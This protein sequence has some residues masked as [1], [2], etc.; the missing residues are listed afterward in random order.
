MGAWE[1]LLADTGSLVAAVHGIP[2]RPGSIGQ[3]PDDL[4]SQIRQGLAARG[5]D[6]PWKHQVD[7]FAA[8]TS[9]RHTVIATGTGSGKSL[10]A[11]APLLNRFAKA[12]RAV[13]LKDIGVSPTALYLSPT[14]A[15]A[16]DQLAG[17][18]DIV[19]ACE[20]EVAVDAVDGDST[21]EARR[22]ARAR[23]D[24]IL[25]NPDFLHFRLLPQ[26]R[27]WTR[28]WKGFTA[29]IVDEFHSYRGM[30]GAHMA[31]VVRR[32]LR[33]ARH[34][35]A[36]PT[37]IFLSATA[38]DP[39]GAAAR[40]LGVPASDIELIDKD[41]S[42]SSGSR[43]IVARPD[44]ELSLIPQASRAAATLIDAGASTLVFSRSRAG[45]E[46][47][48]EKMRE[49]LEQ[50]FSPFAEQVESYRGGYLP[51]ERREL[52][53]DLRSGRLRGLASTNALELGIDI[54]GLDAVVMAGWPGTHASF[55]QQLGRAGRG[56]TPGIGI[57]ITRDDPLDQHY[58]EHATTLLDHPLERQVFNPHNPYIVQ[59]HLL[60]AA[61]ELALT[62]ADCAAF[63][64]ETT[65]LLEEIAAGGL[66]I[67]R[68]E[69][70]RWNVALGIEP[71]SLID[72]R[73]SAGEI[74][75]VE[76]SSGQVIGTVPAERAD[77]TVHPG[78]IYMHRGRAFHVARLEEN[79]ALVEATEE[80]VR[81]RA[82]SQS[83]VEIMSVE[84]ERSLPH[85]TLG[86]GSVKVASRVTGYDVRTHRGDF[87]GHE[88]L[89]MPLRELETA[90][91]WWT[92]SV[93]ACSRAGIT[94]DILPG[95]LHGLEHCAIGLLPIFAT[96]DRWDIGGLSTAEHPQT[97]AP[98]IIVHDA[99][100]GG[101]GCAEQGYQRITE[102][103][104]AATER[105]AHCPCEQGCPA[106]VQSPKCGNRNSPLSKT[107]ALLLGTLMVDELQKG[108]A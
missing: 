50:R 1:K 68:G 37:V 93:T 106:C 23:G 82:L 2:S 20:L 36:S 101:S 55:R 24:I 14:K 98:T 21:P 76:R 49:V 94:P 11:W 108:P 70:W 8:I 90:G 28:L 91:C 13:S 48:A 88:K 15:L 4:H 62:A 38:H 18:T 99:I 85:G 43:L 31:L 64:L 83:A 53:R 66:L 102:W 81:T 59:G 56:A 78:A 45:T 87:I 25:S 86:F 60:C 3:W 47:V 9:G 10:A 100:H 41:G 22:S 27:R 17:L 52:E 61:A 7:A 107:G 29:I 40:F 89:E 97:G 71:H 34:Y 74:A 104:T 51:E 16:A 95:A 30:S 58:A 105:L 75:I 65:E 6:R 72:L 12:R 73:S 57:L 54:S 79:T 33:I 84:A 44:P 35:G 39:R 103:L 92:V 26:H 46:A 63:G 19:R 42:A 96:C 32:A 67:Q 5:I 80:Q 77:A 69:A